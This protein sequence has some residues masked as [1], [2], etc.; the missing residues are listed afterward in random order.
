MMQIGV[1]KF[2]YCLYIFIYKYMCL[3]SAR[4]LRVREEDEEGVLHSQPAIRT[5]LVSRI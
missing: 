4:E 1:M 3:S 2:E 5:N